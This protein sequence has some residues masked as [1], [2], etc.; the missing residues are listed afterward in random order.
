M[1][2]G[3]K[4]PAITPDLK[5]GELLDAYPG[6]EDVLIEIAPAF[7]KLRNPVLRRTV[8][9]LTSIRQA[10]QVG[11]VS[12]GEIIGK[13]RSAAGC[14]EAWADEHDAPPGAGQ[15]PEWV[16]SGEVVEIFDAV[17]M[18]EA[19]GH[20]L[21]EMMSALR[22]LGPGQIYAVV[23]PF[24]PAPMIDKVREQGYVTWTEQLGAEKFK[25]YFMRLRT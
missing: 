10:A 21:P 9:K 17:E 6:L 12:L 22:K 11:G 20:P 3:S 18:I 15:R 2:D 8:A 5:V 24:V 4:R 13:L 7:K 19:G 25:S 16:D 14:E 1:A 23:T